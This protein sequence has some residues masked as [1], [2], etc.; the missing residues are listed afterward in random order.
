MIKRGR[1]QAI[2]FKLKTRKDVI[3]SSLYLLCF[4]TTIYRLYN[5]KC[6]YLGFF[7]R[8]TGHVMS[9]A[10]KKYI[11]P[12]KQTVTISLIAFLYI[13]IPEM[14]LIYLHGKQSLQNSR[15]LTPNM[16]LHK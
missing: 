1:I 11:S 9:G 10:S 5:C 15:A 6:V 3:I 12:N 2:S 8:H 7:K 16:Y 4:N 13:L 14:I